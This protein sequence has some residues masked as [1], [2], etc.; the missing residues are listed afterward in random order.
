MIK[1]KGFQ[2]MKKKIWPAMICPVLF[3]ILMRIL[4]PFIYGMVDDRS[5]MEIVSGQYTGMPDP[6]MIFT[7]YWYG[8][9]VA[10][11]YWL[12]PQVDWYALCML[13]LEAACLGLMLYRLMGKRQKRNW[14]TALFF[15]LICVCMGIRPV[16]QVTFTTTGAILAVALIFWY[17]TM[18]EIHMYDL[19]VLGAL[20]LF[21][22][23]LRFSVYVM[24]LPVCGVLWLFRVWK[25]KGRDKK[26]LLIP[27]IVAGVLGI[28][29][30]GILVGYG[31]KGWTSYRVYN[32]NRSLIYDYE[33]YMFPRFEDAQVLYGQVGVESKARAKNLY[34]YNYTAD[35]QVNQE[36]F[37]DYLQAKEEQLK[38]EQISILT[39]LKQTLKT[40]VKSAVS[41]K[42][43]YVHLVLL[44][45]YLALIILLLLKREY[46]MTAKVMAVFA[47]QI[48]LWLYLVWRGRTPERV[49]ISMNLMLVEPLVL[50]WTGAL[51]HVQMPAK[52]V[53]TGT[54]LFL[55]IVCI[56]AGVQIKTVRAEN[57]E[58]ARWNRSVEDLKEYCMDHPENFYFNDVTSLAMTTWNVHLWNPKQYRMNYMSLGDWMSFSPIW[59]EKL[60]QNG[61]SSV[62]EA[63]YGQ[64]NIYLISSFDRGTEYLT[65]LYDGVT[66]EQVDTI[67]QFKVYRLVKEAG[68]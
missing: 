11:F 13:A 36:F 46:E 55:V 19:I 61:I 56:Y 62:R 2:K 35:D 6:H 25:E 33:D 24:V 53:K 43:G 29:G 28:Y 48:L 60:E 17:M 64:D 49:L 10:G 39:K 5:M 21:A 68:K 9:L 50:F 44:G 37:A 14:W 20:G 1:K 3:I 42:Y 40:Y 8:L 16:T 63:L 26:N 15:L 57:V 51:K 12:L 4:I 58:Q 41:G 59:Q 23:E 32:D 66:C 27:V 65:E 45:G 18:E 22:V 30:M 7:G 38:S 34:Y 54:A 67:R 47:V 52:V 31:N